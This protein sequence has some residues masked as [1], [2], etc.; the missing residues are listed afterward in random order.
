MS[1]ATEPAASPADFH[2]NDQVFISFYD[3]DPIMIQRIKSRLLS[4]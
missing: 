2:N 3:F 1:T 4:V